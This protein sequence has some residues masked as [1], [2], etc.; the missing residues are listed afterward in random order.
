MKKFLEIY[1]GSRGAI[2]SVEEMEFENI[3]EFLESEVKNVL[4]V[5]YEEDE[6]DDSVLELFNWD[7]RGDEGYL[8]G[9]GDEEEKVYIDVECEGFK[10]WSVDNNIDN[11]NEIVRLNWDDVFEDKI[12]NLLDEYVSIYG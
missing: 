11:I 4:S 5:Y 12:R 9:L 1:L 7:K 10:R 2:E 3:E 6:I 8:L